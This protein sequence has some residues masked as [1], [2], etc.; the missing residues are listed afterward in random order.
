MY[1]SVLLKEPCLV[2]LL[3]ASVLWEC[4]MHFVSW[5]KGFFTS[6]R[7]C[8]SPA[9]QTFETPPPLPHIRMSMVMSRHLLCLW[10]EWCVCLIG[11]LRAICFLGTLKLASVRFSFRDYPWKECPPFSLLFSN[12]LTLSLLS[13]SFLPS[14]RNHGVT[15]AQ[16]WGRETSSPLIYAALVWSQSTKLC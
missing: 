12:S 2:C 16:M 14:A 15:L 10:K 1:C 9:V 6:D 7:W 13:S 11:M 8:F 4:A 5:P 3:E